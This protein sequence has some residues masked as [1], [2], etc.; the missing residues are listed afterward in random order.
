METKLSPEQSEAVYFPSS[1]ASSGN[2]K[3][4]ARNLVIEAGAG[5]GK[6]TLLTERVHWLLNAAPRAY[7]LDPQ[8]LILVTFSRAADEELRRG[9]VEEQ[10][11]A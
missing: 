10:R 11:A 1:T 4:T 5:A 9:R 2:L 8:E 7:R 6:T 3:P